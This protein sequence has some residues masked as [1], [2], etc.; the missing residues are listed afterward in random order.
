MN[1]ETKIDDVDPVSYAFNKSIVPFPELADEKLKPPVSEI[2]LGDTKDMYKPP[3]EL[4][5]DEKIQERMDEYRKAER[6]LIINFYTGGSAY[7]KGIM[8]AVY[9]GSSEL[10]G[11]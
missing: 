10:L 2:N 5:V 11:I 1:Q 6:A 8:D 7:K 9:R 3:R 4:T